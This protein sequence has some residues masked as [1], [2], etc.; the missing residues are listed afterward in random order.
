MYQAEYMLREVRSER[1][2]RLHR[3]RNATRAH[4]AK[5]ALA[6]ADCPKRFHYPAIAR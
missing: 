4:L 5:R 2:E 1:L 3:L 6:Q